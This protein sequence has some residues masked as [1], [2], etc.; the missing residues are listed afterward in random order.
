[1]EVTTDSYMIWLW[2]GHSCVWAVGLVWGDVEERKV[3]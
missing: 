2:G 3:T 1:M